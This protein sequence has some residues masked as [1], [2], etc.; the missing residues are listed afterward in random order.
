[1]G[2]SWGRKLPDAGDRGRLPIVW[3]V[4]HAGASGTA[5]R[6]EV[7][8]NLGEGGGA[9]GWPGPGRR[10]K[11]WLDPGNVPG[12]S[13]RSGCGEEGRLPIVWV[14]T[15]VGTWGMAVERKSLLAAF[16][17]PAGL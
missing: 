12:V 8:S 5:A 3:V 13:T 2:D 1:M 10:A 16:V 9:R 6:A 15:H 4:T 7:D 11:E 17:N 14:V